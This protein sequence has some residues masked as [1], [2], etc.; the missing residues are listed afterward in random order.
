MSL[1]SRACDEKTG[2][3]HKGGGVPSQIC[4][5]LGAITHVRRKDFPVFPVL[6]SV[7][8]TVNRKA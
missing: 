1:Q 5:S 3:I 4:A 2:S 7:H 6:T 8:P